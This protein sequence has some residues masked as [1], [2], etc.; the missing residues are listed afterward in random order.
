[1]VKNIPHDSGCQLSLVFEP[2]L[3]NRHR[4]LRECM[5][6]GV[7]AVGLGRVAVQVDEAPSHLSEKLAGGTGD[8]NRDVGC[9]LLERYL[10][11]TGDKTPIYYL[12][13][14]YLRN[15]HAQHDAALLDLA[16]LARALPALLA[17]A[18]VKP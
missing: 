3:S 8:R 10:D 15:S 6:A 17:A 1:M 11:K 12:I 4:S 16:K 5:A 2:G 7:Y 13:D 18:G 14:K 9:D